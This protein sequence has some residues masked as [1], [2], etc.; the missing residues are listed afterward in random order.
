MCVAVTLVPGTTLSVDEVTRM[1]RSNADG[2]GLAWARDGMVSWWKTL[3]VDPDYVTK[4][5]NAWKDYPRLLHFRYATAGGARPD[6]CHPFEIGP[7]ANCNVTGTASKVMIHN[8]H[9]G[10]WED[11][12]K[13]FDGSN[14]L[15]PGP[16]SDSRLVA[17]LAHEDPEW[18]TALGGRVAVM[19]GDGQIVRLGDWTKLRDGL[20][21]SNDTWKSATHTRGGYAGYRQWKGWAWSEEEAQAYQEEQEKSAREAEKRDTPVESLRRPTA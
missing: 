13:L 19:G 7:L 21:V 15:P 5:I 16:W 18:L 14:L 8:G 1:H 9:W 10:R 11:V 3:S 20:M 2:V 4:A 6:L 17:F 12:K